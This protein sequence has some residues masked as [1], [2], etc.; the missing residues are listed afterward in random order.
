MLS[1]TAVWSFMS[2]Q[3]CSRYWRCRIRAD[4]RMRCQWRP[5]TSPSSSSST[6]SILHYITAQ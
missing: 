6:G 4:V 2:M 1:Y 5:T 3:M